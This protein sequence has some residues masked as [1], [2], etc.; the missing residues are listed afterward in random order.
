MPEA[1]QATAFEAIMLEA[2]EIAPDI[3][4]YLEEARRCFSAQAYNAMVVMVWC[5][6]IARLL[7]EI[8]Y[9]GGKPIFEP[10]YEAEYG[11]KPPDDLKK[12]EDS[13]LIRV[14][15]R[16]G[17][18]SEET[19]NV[20][21]GC[22][23][24]R[25]DCAH[26]S[27]VF[28]TEGDEVL[29]YLREISVALLSRPPQVPWNRITEII[30]TDKVNL[31]DAQASY[32]ASRIT[33]VEK[34]HEVMNQLLSAFIT[35]DR[36]EVRRNILLV[37]PRLGEVLIHQRK[38]Q[39]MKRL[40]KELARFLGIRIVERDS[41]IEEHPIDDI[42]SFELDATEVA[43]LV[44]W[45]DVERNSWY[46]RWIYQYLV[47]EYERFASERS[48]RGIDAMVLRRLYE[49]ASDEFRERCEKLREI[50]F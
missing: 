7:Y 3:H 35:T 45:E 13:K 27:D 20:L 38:I 23:E 12:V 6:V 5:A 30:R 47:S 22:R 31:S 33:P 18:I 39:L 1:G 32:L 46:Q 37:W 29:L 8:K 28:V 50:V 10:E 24:K 4:P 25:N 49:H 15:K 36:F 2:C 17:L 48:G 40:A 42:P 9:V 11:R 44:F 41:D 19:E 21:N 26:P 16:L 43:E 14:C 34:A